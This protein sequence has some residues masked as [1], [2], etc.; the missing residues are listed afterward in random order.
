M[1]LQA[2]LV[3]LLYILR[4]CQLFS[5]RLL[6]QNNSPSCLEQRN[7]IQQLISYAVGNI[8]LRCNG[9]SCNIK[10]YVAEITLS[11]FRF[12]APKRVRYIERAKPK[13]QLFTRDLQPCKQAKQDEQ[14]A[15][16]L[17]TA[18]ISTALRGDVVP[19]TRRTACIRTLAALNSACRQSRGEHR[20][21][22]HSIYLP[23]TPS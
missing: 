20:Y 11:S 14:N 3:N 4:Y 19:V 17:L 23:L 22:S 9:T 6:T 7:V 2:R 18:D 8:W 12:A 21:P 1:Q 13:S 5:E 15:Q 16:T 10:T